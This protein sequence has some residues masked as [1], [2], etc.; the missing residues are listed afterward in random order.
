M[1]T[2]FPDRVRP[3]V[4][5]TWGAGIHRTMVDRRTTRVVDL[6]RARRAS[7]RRCSGRSMIEALDTRQPCH[8]TSC[9]M[10]SGGRS[11]VVRRLLVHQTASCWPLHML[12]IRSGVP[13]ASSPFQ[14]SVRLATGVRVDRASRADN[15]TCTSS[16]LVKASG[17]GVRAV[18]SRRVSVDMAWLVR[19]RHRRHR[20]SPSGC[21]TRG[22]EVCGSWSNRGRLY[23]KT[24]TVASGRKGSRSRSAVTTRRLRMIVS[25]LSG[26]SSSRWSVRVDTQS[27]LRSALVSHCKGWRPSPA[28]VR[29]IADSRG[30]RRNARRRKVATM[31]PSMTAYTSTSACS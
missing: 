27:T 5:R 14:L 16:G 28:I 10:P 31:T 30:C 6:H 4:I 11:G 2:S 18:V 20:Q 29:K 23:R 8:L 7:R 13:S 12:S 9:G 19:A 21:T 1:Q 24:W 17:G 15:A 25:V 26:R 22:R 3:P